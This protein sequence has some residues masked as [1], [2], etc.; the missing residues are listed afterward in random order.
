MGS[1]PGPNLKILWILTVRKH[2]SQSCNLVLLHVPGRRSCPIHATSCSPCV[3]GDSVAQ[4]LRKSGDALLRFREPNH[5][6]AALR[7]KSS[8]L[9]PQKSAMLVHSNPHGFHKESVL[10][11]FFHHSFT[12]GLTI[13]PVTNLSI[14]EIFAFLGCYTVS[15]RRFGKPIGPILKD[16]YWPLKILLKQRRNLEITC[17]HIFHVSDFRHFN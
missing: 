8:S 2:L 14:Y 7:P 13:S 15:Y 9:L 1:G 17:Y 4:L 11:K 12:N 10:E 6:H 3:F 16:Q 5:S